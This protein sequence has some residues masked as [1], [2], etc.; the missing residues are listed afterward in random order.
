MNRS[1]NSALEPCGEPRMATCGSTEY[2][3]DADQCCAGMRVHKGARER[4]LECC[5]PGDDIYDPAV[6][7]C[8]NSVVSKER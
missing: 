1:Y 6:E 3:P 2:D 5:N 8:C 4:G 7:Y